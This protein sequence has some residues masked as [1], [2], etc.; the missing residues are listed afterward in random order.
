MKLLQITPKPNNKVKLKTA[1]NEK[2]RAIRNQGTTFVKTG[3][4]K[5]KHTKHKGW[6]IWQET[7]GNIIIAEIKSKVPETEWQITQSFISY[8]DRHFADLIESI[9][10]L[11]R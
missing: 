2:E 10:I 4:G 8:L 1:M 7:Y 6:I 3:I 11:Y 9:M 5:W